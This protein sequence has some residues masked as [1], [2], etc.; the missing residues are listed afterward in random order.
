MRST[1]FGTS[2]VTV[3]AVGLGLAAL[4]RPGYLTLGHGED[5]A[6]RTD[7]AA[8]ERHAHRMLDAARAAG[9]VYFDAARSY[10]RSEEF[11]ASWLRSRGVASDAVVVG[12]KWGYIYRADWRTDAEVHEVKLHSL[13]NLDRQYAESSGR[14]GAHLRLY[15]IHSATTDSGVL[16]DRAVMSRLAELRDAGVIVGVTVSGPGQAE[17]IRRALTIAPGGTPL[18][19]AVQ[20]TWNLLETSAGQALAEAADAGLAVIVKE[21]VANGRLSARNPSI[22]DRLRGL[23]SDWPVDALAMAAVLHQ[24]W[25]TVVLS[26]AATEEQ[27]ASNLRALDVP[28]DVVDRLPVLSEPPGQYWATRTSLDWT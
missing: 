9:V 11:L 10:G 25:A 14:L 22:L 2:G 28:A 21:A 5:L 23:G 24:P 1:S 17:T 26:G 27:L 12:S 20:A 13:E 16:E 15:Q 8:L 19:G 7:V 4:G 6:G 18:F 3:S